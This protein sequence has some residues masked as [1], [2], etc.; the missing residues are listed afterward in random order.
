MKMKKVKSKKTMEQ[1][2]EN[3]KNGGKVRAT[4]FCAAMGIDTWVIK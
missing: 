3:M 4:D 2:L 1:Y